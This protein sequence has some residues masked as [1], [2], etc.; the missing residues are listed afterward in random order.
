MPDSENKQWF[1]KDS[2]PKKNPNPSNRRPNGK[3]NK[4]KVNAN[5]AN[6]NRPNG[7]MPNKAGNN[8]PNQPARNAGR[9]NP[10][11]PKNDP[12]LRRTPTGKNA[13]DAR[14]MHALDNPNQ[15]RVKPNPDA[16]KKANVP[17]VNKNEGKKAVLNN[18]PKKAKKSFKFK[19][20]DKKVSEVKKENT[21]VTPVE[22]KPTGFD[23]QKFDS[24]RKKRSRKSVMN[25]ALIAL[26]VCL[27]FVV[28]LVFVIHHLFDYIAAKPD[29]TFISNGSVEHT[30]GARA[31]IVRDEVLVQTSTTG[32]L[33][34]QA[35]EG[36]R[37]YK[38]QRIGMVVPENMQTVVDSL[39]NTQSQ[40][41]DVQQELIQT[42]LAEGAE[43]IYEDFNNGLNPIV[44]LIRLDAMDG[45]I[46]DMS[47]YASSIA[48]LL[49]QR[50]TTLS[51]LNFDDERLRVLR[52]DEA[53]YENQLSRNAST[54][55]ATSPGVI[56]FRMDGMESE[57]TFNVLLESSTDTI[58]NYISDSVGVIPT[59]LAVENG[60]YVA[61]I[62]SNERQYIACFL[63][64]RTATAEAFK[65]GSPHTI[66]IGSEGISIGKCIVERVEPTSHGLLVVFSTTRYVEDLLDLRSVDIE[67]VINETQGLRVP[68]TSLVNPDF[69]RNIA[70]IYVNNQGFCDEV[71]VI[72]EDY[73]REF[74]I[75]APIGDGSVP[76][77]QTV[78][79][80]NPSSIKPGEKVDN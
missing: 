80:T 14:K 64:E 78:I 51:E 23:K 28:L 79:V 5:R 77:L 18:K 26:S 17:S 19:K 50:E 44:D 55:R 52:S 10:N 60:D 9:N 68:I 72:I 21:V 65:L 61:R 27:L 41:S 33:V 76:N 47:S 66:N 53:A 36:S 15:Q 74:A 45:K 39:R 34:T 30:I 43:N 1:E 35:T 12:S 49:N 6:M 4:K 2:A 20:K 48:V 24:E 46:S 31:L 67:V 54:I 69:D 56:S 3:N 57:L 58:Y 75:I 29:L 25:K 37:V 42:G 70:S 11:I 16:A 73:D 59:N 7:Q 13:S 71:G 8:Q 38:N 22:T 32:D 63:D 62:A 40:I